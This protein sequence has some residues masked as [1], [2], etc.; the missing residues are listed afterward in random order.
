[1]T[2]TPDSDPL[3]RTAVEILFTRLERMETKIDRIIVKLDSVETSHG[4]MLTEILRR[5]P[6]PE[7]GPHA[8]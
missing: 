5:V 6:P 4:V 3:A 1:M 7:G 2:Q 8:D